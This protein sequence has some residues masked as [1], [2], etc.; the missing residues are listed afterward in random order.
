[1]A[2]RRNPRSVGRVARDVAGDPA[3]A[4]RGAERVV[5]RT[6]A[7]DEAGKG[8]DPCSTRGAERPQ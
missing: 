3:R 2:Q 4:D 6:G 5:R 8:Q 1:M 7:G